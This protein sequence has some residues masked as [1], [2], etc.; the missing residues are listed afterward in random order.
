ME[1]GT[2]ITAG[3]TDTRITDD[4]VRD[5][6]DTIGGTGGSA[7]RDGGNPHDPNPGSA[8]I[9]DQVST[10]NSLG[11]GGGMTVTPQT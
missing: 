6:P 3:G 4:Q 10:E 8:S 11:N 5:R 1:D 7:D 9:S 2:V